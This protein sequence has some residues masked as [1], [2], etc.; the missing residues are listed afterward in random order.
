MKNG[1]CLA[2]IL[3][4][5]GALGLTACGSGGGSSTPIV[6]SINTDVSNIETFQTVQ[7]SATVTGTSNTAVTWELSCNTT[8]A[9]VCGSMSASG[10][11][12]APNTV[13]T[14]ATASSTDPAQLIVTAI[15][16][17]DS[18]ASATTSVFTIASLNMQ[19][20]PAPVPLGSSGGNANAICLT[21]APGFCFG[22]TLGSLLTSNA[23]PPA[24]VILSNNHVLG[25]SDGATVGQEVTQPGVIETGCSLTGTINVATVT[26]IIS[27]QSQ[28]VPAFPVDVTTAQITTGQVDLT[29]T[30]L[31][32]GAVSNGVPQPAPPAAGTGMVATVN[33]LLA[34]SGRT[35]GL[36]CANVESL[37]ASA[38]VGYETGCATTTS[39]N[40]TYTDEIV[41]ANMSN[42]QSFIGDGDSGSLAVDEATAQPVALMFAG[43]DTS[44]IGNPVV[45]V[46]NALH[47]STG[48][49][50]SFVGGAQHTVPG[51]SLSGLSSVKVTPQS[52]AALPAGTAQRGQ[53][54]AVS[55][56]TQIM[57]TPG[58]SAY[59]GG[60]SLDA[61]NEPAVLMFVAPGA[62]H[63]S[64][65]LTIDGVRTRLIES[66]SASARGALSTQQSSHHNRSRRNRL[67]VPTPRSRKPNP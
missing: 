5:A 24:M 50:Y 30:I 55:Y 1:A 33:Q 14:L 4:A 62:S 53:A 8:P 32:L 7:F 59:G 45:D 46:L 66:N 19:P 44:A 56:S 63:S 22:G 17:A 20:Y 42:E 21:P 58:V 40:V 34:K 65:P 29:G 6:V 36:T 64:I 39:F 43:S 15:S 54:A 67:Q 9:S 48:H 37:D 11:Y 2:G 25:L 41:V 38:E 12:V 60:G 10:M 28:P 51:C 23:T 16:Q 27:L 18:N 31:E 61:P 52:A 49:T 47:T 3:A 13:P 57:N 35:T 26:N